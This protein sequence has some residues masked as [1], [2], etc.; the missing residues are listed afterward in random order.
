[1]SGKTTYLFA[2]ALLSITLFSACGS[3]SEKETSEAGKQDSIQTTKEAT[4]EKLFTLPAPMQVVSAIKRS[5]AKYAE[6][7]L[8]PIKSGFS[9]DFSKLLNLGI[10]SVDLGYANVYE[11]KQTSLNYFSTAAKIADDIKI[12]GAVNTETIKKFKENINN[13][14]SV[15]RFTLSSFSDIHN[16][17]VANNRVDEAYLIITGCFIEGVYLSAKAYEKEKNKNVLTLVGQQKL[18]LE[19]LIELLSNHQEKK[20]MPELIA[21]LSELKQ[22][23]DSLE[24]RYASAADSGTKSIESINISD[25]VFAKISEK[26]TEIRNGIIQ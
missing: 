2:G 5:G 11:Q 25:E 3:S 15:T 23:Y 19:S 13:K 8:C 22:I 14:D 9:S 26:V 17:L 21:K 20:E 12:V 10:Y 18:F 6:S 24:I 16:N 1:M 7:N 4:G